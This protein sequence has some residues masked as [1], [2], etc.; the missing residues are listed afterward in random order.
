MPG[1]FMRLT[2]MLE[3][4]RELYIE[5]FGQRYPTSTEIAVWK[6]S[7]N[8][9]SN[10]FLTVSNTSANGINQT[11]S[12]IRAVTRQVGINNLCW[13]LIKV[14]HTVSRGHWSSTKLETRIVFYYEA[15]MIL[16]KLAWQ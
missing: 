7:W 15:D 13:D 4:N 16:F 3:K 5:L 2:D 11:L 9:T 12:Q 8:E 6:N 10:Y 1:S 14:T